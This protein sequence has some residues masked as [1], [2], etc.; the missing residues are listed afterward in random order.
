MQFRDRGR[1][2]LSH[3]DVPRTRIGCIA[4]P[5]EGIVATRRG[6]IHRP[7]LEPPGRL[8][9]VSSVSRYQG[10][11]SAI[12]IRLPSGPGVSHLN[13]YS[14]IQQ[15]VAERVGSIQP[16]RWYAPRFVADPRH[17]A[18]PFSQLASRLDGD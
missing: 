8:P 17:R 14:S 13:A 16:T 6:R 2:R 12:R 15:F 9:E 1:L 10:T 4:R 11:P 7:Q 5:Q 3:S 18:L